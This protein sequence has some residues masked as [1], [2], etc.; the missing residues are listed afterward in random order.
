[1][2]KAKKTVSKIVETINGSAAKKGRRVKT[3]TELVADIA[4]RKLSIKAVIEG[5]S[6]N[7]LADIEPL[8]TKAMASEIGTNHTKLAIKLRNPIKLA[9]N[10]VIRL[11]LYLS[12]DANLIFLQITKEIK[13]N[14]DLRSKLNTFKSVKDMK[15][16]NTK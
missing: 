16:Y 8:I 15:Q 10:D 4:A 1:M 11:S 5:G 9:V 2:A 3:I 6:W 7:M 13:S 14:K 12:V